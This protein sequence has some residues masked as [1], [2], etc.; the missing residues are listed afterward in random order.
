M[1]GNPRAQFAQGVTEAVNRLYVSPSSMLDYFSQVQWTN[2]QSP[3]TWNV[4]N[5]QDTLYNVIPNPGTAA[6]SLQAYYSPSQP[7]GGSSDI[8]YAV[9]DPDLIGAGSNIYMFMTAAPCQ[10]EYPG[11]R[12]GGSDG[13]SGV[14]GVGGPQAAGVSGQAGAQPPS[15]TEAGAGVSGQGGEAIPGTRGG[16]GVAGVGA[17]SSGSGN[18]GDGGFGIR[19]QGA[20]GI[21]PGAGVF[22]RGGPVLSPNS[23]VGAGVVGFSGDMPDPDQQTL[24]PFPTLAGVIGQSGMW[25]GVVGH[26]QNYVGVRAHSGLYYPLQEPVGASPA[27]GGVFSSGLLQ[28]EVVGGSGK[29]PFMQV[30]SVLSL[31][32]NPA[33]A[34][35][36]VR[37]VPFLLGKVPGAKNLPSK[38][39]DRRHGLAT[40]AQQRRGVHAG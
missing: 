35:A 14:Y 19:G 31:G 1:A 37:L 24:P 12:D 26:N 25:T 20:A 6:Y 33:D 18:F 28:P 22:G 15:G 4:A 11:R 27:P 3:G 13:G 2:G 9:N 7:L 34:Q 39:G 8:Y 16:A 23:V 38:G 10:N 30:V 17:L 32:G 29:Q 5:G 40:D 36:Q 21:E